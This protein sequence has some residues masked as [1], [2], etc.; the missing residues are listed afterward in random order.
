MDGCKSLPTGSLTLSPEVVFYIEVSKL[1]FEMR[2]R[3]ESDLCYELS[4]KDLVVALDLPSWMVR[5]SKDEL[6][7]IFHFLCL[8]LPRNELFCA[9]NVDF[10]WNPSLLQSEIKC[11]DCF[12]CSLTE[13]SS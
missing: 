6:G 7:S 1:F 2:K 9:I 5:P 12:E 8:E 10:S 4:V 13:V 3:S 11:I